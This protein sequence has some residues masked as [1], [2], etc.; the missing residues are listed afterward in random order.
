MIVAPAAGFPAAL[1]LQ[2]TVLI[3]KYAFGNTR[4]NMN[5]SQSLQKWFNTRLRLSHPLWF[6]T[7][8]PAL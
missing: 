8:R 3:I 5:L 1:S 2:V 6:F 4:L 7:R